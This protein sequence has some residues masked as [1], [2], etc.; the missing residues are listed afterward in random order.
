[1]AG[2]NNTGKKASL[3]LRNFRYPEA[4][5]VATTGRGYYYDPSYGPHSVVDSVCLRVQ[6]MVSRAVCSGPALSN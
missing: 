2:E 6:N 5:S 3:S 4:T 1:M